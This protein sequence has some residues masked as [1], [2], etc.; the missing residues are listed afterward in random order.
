MIDLNLNTQPKPSPASFIK[1]T[2]ELNF[3]QDVLQA[4]MERPVIAL[5]YSPASAICKQMAA[6]LEKLASAAVLLARVD[7]T[8]NPGLAQALRL[9]AVPTVY[10]F[11]QGRPI[12][13]FTGA[14]TDAELKSMVDDLKKFGGAPEEM[15][16]AALAEQT[17]KIRDEADAFFGQGNLDAAM[18]RYATALETDPSDMEALAGIG[19]CL[20]GQG[21]VAAVREMLT[22][23]SPEQ[24][25]TPRLKGLKNLM[26]LEDNV[27]DID[28]ALALADRMM[29][30]PKDLQA[31]YDL[32][33]RHLAA[34]QLEKGIDTLIGIIRLDREWQEQKARKLLL[35]V[36]ESLGNAHPLTSSGRR[37]LSSVLFS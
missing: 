19:W 5:F 37:K 6:A 15:D 7:I 9:E 32:A 3:E 31:R 33:Q 20:L 24:L 25:E 36:F 17:K 12:D 27:K 23:L 11:H 10:V 35:E 2:D 13:G 29:K 18:E 26:A 28:D 1:D 8:R 16:K 22:G 14:K 21:D 30:N 34:G 4:S